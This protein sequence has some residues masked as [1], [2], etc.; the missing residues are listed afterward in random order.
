MLPETTDLK[1]TK[2]RGIECY[3]DA[4]RPSK[5]K[6]FAPCLKSYHETANDAKFKIRTSRLGLRKPTPSLASRML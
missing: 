4:A 1:D 2:T 3:L 5:Q 6:G